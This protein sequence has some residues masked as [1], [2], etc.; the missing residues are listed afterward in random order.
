MSF[1]CRH[2]V[3]PRDP[4]Q[5]LILNGYWPTDKFTFF[6]QVVCCVLLPGLS[7]NPFHWGFLRARRPGLRLAGGL[8][9]LSV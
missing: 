6:Y 7:K 8:Q 2:L 4:L 9:S 5:T 1:P 3:V